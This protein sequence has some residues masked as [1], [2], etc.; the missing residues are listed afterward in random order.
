MPLTVRKLISLSEEDARRL[1]EL[2]AINT[3]GNQTALLRSLLNRAYLLPEQF[4]LLDPEL[5]T[6]ASDRETILN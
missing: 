2:A 6:I 5:F 4:G 1:K 3:G